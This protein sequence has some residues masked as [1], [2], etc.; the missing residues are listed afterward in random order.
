VHDNNDASFRKGNHVSSF[1]Q[2]TQQQLLNAIVGTM[3]TTAATIA[4]TI[5]TL[6]YLAQIDVSQAL[7]D[8][9]FVLVS[10]CGSFFLVLSSHVEFLVKCPLASGDSTTRT[11]SGDVYA[12]LYACFR[13][14]VFKVNPESLRVQWDPGDVGPEELRTSCDDLMHAVGTTADGA[15][16]VHA[17]FGTPAAS[18]G[19]MKSGARDLARHL[20]GS[21]IQSLLD[22]G[23]KQE[24][25]QAYQLLDRLG[26]LF[27]ENG[28]RP[29]PYSRLA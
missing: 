1:L 19:L 13:N 27:G 11:V 28:F 29:E 21:S 26:G 4:T 6:F 16:A 17:V 18:G 24:H 23:A 12:F 22:R 14:N 20:F 10:I 5:G 15:C 25:V 7:S 9:G 2:R 3:P 8:V